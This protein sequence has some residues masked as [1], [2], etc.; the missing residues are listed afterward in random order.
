MRR[1]GRANQV[2]FLIRVNHAYWHPGKAEIGDYW[3]Y[4]GWLGVCVGGRYPVID[5][6]NR[7]SD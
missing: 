7:R 4:R 5:E 6:Q 1:V 3:V 2:N